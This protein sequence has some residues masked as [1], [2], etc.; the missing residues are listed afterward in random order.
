MKYPLLHQH[1]SKYI[2]GETDQIEA[3]CALYS[4]Q[5][6]KKKEYLLQAGQVC[7]VEA[8]IVQ[9]LVRIYHIDRNGVEQILFFGAEDWW[10]TDFD[11][12]MHQTPSQLYIQALEDSQLLIITPEDKQ[13]AYEHIPITERLFRLMAVR[14]HIALQRRMLDNLSKTAEE[15]YRDFF[16]KYPHI[17]RRLTNVQL[18]GYLGVTHEFISK[19]RRKSVQNKN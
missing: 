18:A 16:T 14:T 8:F 17:A 6:L 2:T 3:L 1:F 19:I 10:V 15:R 5:T 9:G 4:P 12:F 13:Y 7:K 11:S